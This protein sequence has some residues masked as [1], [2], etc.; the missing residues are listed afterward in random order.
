MQRMREAHNKLSIY[1]NQYVI[2]FKQ[3]VL[4]LLNTM[5]RGIYER[6]NKLLSLGPHLISCSNPFFKEPLN[7][8]CPLP[9]AF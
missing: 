7:K 6:R 1:G 8:L 5:I 2:Y 3:K 9:R 4:I